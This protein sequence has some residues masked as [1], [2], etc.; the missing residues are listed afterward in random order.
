V[1]EDINEINERSLSTLQRSVEMSREFSLILVRCNYAEL[2]ESILTMLKAKLN[3]RSLTIGEIELPQT[4]ETL[5]TT[6]QDALGNERPQALIVTGL[7]FVKNLDQILVATNQV[8]DEFKKKF[9]FPI[10]FWVDDRVLYKLNKLAPDFKSWG[11]ISIRFEETTENLIKFLEKSADRVF[12]LALVQGATNRFLSFPM[13]DPLSLP[14]L[15]SAQKDLSDR[16]AILPPQQVVELEF[17][18]GIDC[19]EKG[20]YDHAIG[21]FQQSLEFWQAA[22][23]PVPAIAE[24]DIPKKQCTEREGVVLYYV[25]L[26]YYEKAKRLNPNSKESF[27]QEAKQYLQQS[28]DT[29][30]RADRLELVAKF[31]GK[32]GEVLDRLELWAEL[33]PLAS[34]CFELHR[35]YDLKLHL[36]QDYAWQADLWLHKQK[37]SEAKENADMALKLLREVSEIPLEARNWF[38]SR[39]LLSLARSEEG[40]GQIDEAIA[41]LETAKSLCI[42]LRRPWVYLKVLKALQKIYRKRGEYL[43]SFEAKQELLSVE[44]QYGFRAFIGAVRLKPQQ[45]VDREEGQVS[46]E[47]LYS[48]RKQD[49]DRLIARMGRDDRKLTIIHGQSGVGKSSLLNAGLVPSLTQTPIQG[50]MVLP[51]LLNTY[52]NWVEALGNDL[53]AIGSQSKEVKQLNGNGYWTVDK[54]LELLRHK[55]DHYLTPVLIFDQ[56]EEFFFFCATPASRSSF[57]QFFKTCLNIPYVKVILSLR[58]DYLHFLLECDR[59]VDLEVVNN[60]ILDKN[61]RYYLGNFSKED[62][63]RIIKELTDRSQTC[64]EDPLIDA[65]VKDL[66]RE[67]GEVLPIELQVVGA[68][69]QSE[70]PPIAALEQYRAL[71]GSAKEELVKRYL[72]EVVE[73]CGSE[74]KEIAKLVLYYLTDE[75]GT[76]PLKTRAELER[77]LNSLSKDSSQEPL[78]KETHSLE[79]VLDIFVKSGLVLLLREVPAE[80]YQLVHDYLAAF[81]HK[82]QE[83]ELNKLIEEL[84]RE[85]KKRK[86][87]ESQI[88]L[89]IGWGILG[90]IL[91]TSLGGLAWLALSSRDESFV[92]LSKYSISLSNLNQDFDALSESLDLSRRLREIPILPANQESR[93]RN[94][95]SL[96]QALSKIK[97]RNQL[98][99]HTDRVLSVDFS[100]DGTIATGSTDKTV[101]LWDSTGKPRGKPLQHEA[102]VRSVSFSPDGKTIVTGSG[103]GK[104]MLWD[105]DTSKMQRLLPAHNDSI[106]SVKFSH[107]GKIIVSASADGEIKLWDSNGNPMRSIPKASTLIT[108]AIFSPDNRFVATAGNDGKVVIIDISSRKVVREIKPQNF[109]SLVKCISFS[110]DGKLVAGYDNNQI[111]LWNPLGKEISKDRQFKGHSDGI[112]SISFSP[113]GNTIASASEDGTIKLWDINGTELQTFKLDTPI[114]SL[115]FSSDGKMLVSGGNDPTVRLW[116]LEGVTKPNK[117]GIGSFNFNF[118]GTQIVSASNDDGIVTLWNFDKQ[119]NLAKI[120]ASDKAKAAPNSTIVDFSPDGRM[121]A[122]AI[123]YSDAKDNG[124]ATIYLRDI[125]ESYLQTLPT[126]KNA[127]I[128]SLR[129][130]PDGKNILIA[131]ATSDDRRPVQLLSRNLKAEVNSVL[132]LDKDS[133]QLL[134]TLKGHSAPIQKISFSPDGQTIA[135]ASADKT[136]KLW[137]SSDKIPIRTHIGHINTVFDVKFSPDGQTIAT[138]S[139]DNTVKLWRSSDWKEIAT[140][141]GHKDSVYSVSFSPDGKILASAGADREIRIWDLKDNKEIAT[142]GGHSMRINTVSFKPDR[143]GELK[144]FLISAGEDGTIVWDL[145][146]EHLAKVGCKWLRDYHNSHPQEKDRSICKDI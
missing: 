35:Q 13:F 116:D 79:R 36:A 53:S 129:M 27:W 67:Q 106:S 56:F 34:R 107:D 135:T 110:K 62:A 58:E 49:L 89:V 10:V 15:I 95:L 134:Y 103:D 111:K 11:A 47:I 72:N 100:S 136:V 46:Q 114:K 104:V 75:K 2:S 51:V 9:P 94:S 4:V 133:K 33:Q 144:Y 77:D 14:E 5:F 38:G 118:D 128:T 81:I 101:I 17:I 92:Y 90:T 32:L 86:K 132:V 143:N 115:S 12:D 18:L 20:E 31:I 25:G 64:L 83:H 48:G 99:G 108:S 140:L 21:H 121:I 93:L 145:D 124:E 37:W 39:F 6:I 19:Y 1:M 59:L 80:R 113:Y 78:D 131:L 69:L 40:L 87:A 26:C 61:F 117:L 98:D 57:W 125:K 139:G 88:R 109:S 66:A 8:R 7:G 42:N 43:K 141:R 70:K 23:Q 97:E 55:T 137:R 44:Q 122:F 138:A 73:D 96:Q 130:S 112:N 82:D 41:D 102:S 76:R 50:R 28:I 30:E 74:N 54:V 45:Q 3:D 127:S 123:N 146:F 105:T 126:I 91:A 120:F 60:N 22:K 24:I 16:G 29:F 68:Q 84:E 142:F 52:T 119:G 63:K 65:L 85:K 71:G